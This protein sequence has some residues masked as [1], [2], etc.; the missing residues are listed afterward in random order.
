MNFKVY[1]ILSALIPGFLGLFILMNALKLQYD[2]DLIIAYTALAFLF[3]YLINTIGSWL[4][5]FYFL[6]WGGKP[7]TQLLDGKDIWKVRFYHSTK[8]KE[9]LTEEFPAAKNNNELFSVA[10]RYAN[11]VERVDTFNAYYAFSRAILTTVL[12]GTIV[13]LF[14]YYQDIRYYLV[15]LPVLFFC[16]LRCKQRAFYY[17]K[18]VLTVYLKEKSK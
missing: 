9:K 10:M 11:G 17:A 15:L 12:F 13:L 6:T 2:K 3:G 7:S 1:D 18:E 5:D 14:T 16:W 8:T 4:E